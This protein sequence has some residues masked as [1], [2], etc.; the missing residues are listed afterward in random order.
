MFFL[1]LEFYAYTTGPLCPKNFG[2]CAFAVGA[3]RKE[4]VFLIITYFFE[5]V[6]PVGLHR[7]QGHMEGNRSVGPLYGKIS[8]I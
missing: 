1:Y 5:I 4:A 6:K 7:T 8:R 2:I 3:G